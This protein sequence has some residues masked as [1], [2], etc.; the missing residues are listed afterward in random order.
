MKH[1]FGHLPFT[2]R[3]RAHHGNLYLHQHS[4]SH[5]KMV[6]VIAGYIYGFETKKWYTGLR[7][8]GHVKRIDVNLAVNISLRPNNTIYVIHYARYLPNDNRQM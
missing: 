6:H 8:K 5:I 4:L 1:L 7:V 3:L 2:R